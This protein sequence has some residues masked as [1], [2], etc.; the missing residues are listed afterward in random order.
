[1][2]NNSTFS[3]ARFEGIL[4][5]FYHLFNDSKRGLYGSKYEKISKNTNTTQQTFAYMVMF[6]HATNGIFK[7]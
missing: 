5:T 1:M 6:L 7:L 4:C 2:S 3:R